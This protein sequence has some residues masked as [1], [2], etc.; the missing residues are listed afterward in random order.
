[1]MPGLTKKTASKGF[2]LV[3]I[4]ISLAILGILAAI[5]IPNYRLWKD[6]AECASM[7]TTLKYLMDGEDFYFLEN[8]RFFPERVSRGEAKEIP[9]LAYNFAEGHKNAYRIRVRNNRRRNRYIIRV[10]CDFDSNGNGRDDRFRAITDIRRGKVRKN[11][12]IVQ[13]R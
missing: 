11:R 7:L 2:T 10:Y 9:E 8:G 6:K 12:E 3:E 1:M 4:M 13:L 5:S